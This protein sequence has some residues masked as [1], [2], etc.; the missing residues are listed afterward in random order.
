MVHT[1][2]TGPFFCSLLEKHN[3]LA[4]SWSLDNVFIYFLWSSDFHDL[5]DRSLNASARSALTAVDST[6]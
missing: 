5:T 3:L 4:G 2:Q 1:Y 6:N